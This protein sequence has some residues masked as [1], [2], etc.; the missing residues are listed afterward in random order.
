MSAVRDLLFRRTVQVE[1]ILTPALPHYKRD[2]SQGR[3]WCSQERQDVLGRR[4]LRNSQQRLVFSQ[5]LH[6]IF[7]SRVRSEAFVRHY[8]LF[9]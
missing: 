2:L 5:G 8:L 3:L 7:S 6:S 4:A 9:D 1:K